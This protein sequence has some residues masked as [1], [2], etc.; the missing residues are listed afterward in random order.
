M[1]KQI[2]SRSWANE[3]RKLIEIDLKVRPNAVDDVKKAIQAVSDNY[4]EKYFPAI[5]SASSLREKFHKVEAYL[6]R[7][8]SFKPQGNESIY[9]NLTKKFDNE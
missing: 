1:N 8:Q 7:L 3:I 4:G 9:S 6:G 5:Q 2:N